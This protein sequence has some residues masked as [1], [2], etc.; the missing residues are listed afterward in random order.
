VL[1]NTEGG[2]LNKILDPVLVTLESFEPEVEAP[3]AAETALK[4]LVKEPR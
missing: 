2:H 3:L 1:H 4:A